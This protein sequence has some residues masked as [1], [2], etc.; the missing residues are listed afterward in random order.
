MANTVTIAMEGIWLLIDF[1][2][3]LVL[4]D[5]ILLLLDSTQYGSTSLGQLI[6][7]T[8]IKKDRPFD[9]GPNISATFKGTKH[10]G[11]LQSSSAVAM[12]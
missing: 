11:T 1:R 10:P 8:G 5:S 3:P 2:W 9:G 12:D 4:S 6:E 7:V